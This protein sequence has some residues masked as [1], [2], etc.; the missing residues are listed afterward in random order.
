MK[1]TFPFLTRLALLLA[2]SAA[3]N[4]FAHSVWIETAK[5]GSLVVRFGEFGA[6]YEKSPGHLDSLLAVGAWTHDAEGKP[7]PFA[8]EKKFDHFLLVDA[9]PASPAQIETGF[10]VMGTKSP[11]RKP[12]FY[13]RWYPHGTP[14]PTVPA[15]DAR[16]IADGQA[17]RSEGALPR[18]ARA[19]REA[20][21]GFP[22]RNG[23][24]VHH[25]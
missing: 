23:T 7:A 2:A 14:V 22:G 13:A 9:K 5:D 16:H 19:R 18:P 11:L 8:V 24:R 15:A 25:R 1:T 17:G 12:V 3:M 4:A 10:P 20:H 21:G 6:K